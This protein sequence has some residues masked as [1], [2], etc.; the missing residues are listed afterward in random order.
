M[1]RRIPELSL[2]L[3]F[4]ASLPAFTSGARAQL[5]LM[6]RTAGHERLDFLLGKWSHEETQTILGE[7]TTVSSTTRYE[8]L[9]GGV[10]LRG[11]ATIWG[12]PG[13]DV[14]HGW[15]Q[16]TYDPAA[17][18]YVQLWSDNQSSILFVKRGSWTDETTLALE[19]AHEWG[20]QTV[21]SKNVYRVL[22]E[23]E[24][25]RE[26]LVSNDGGVTYV[27]RSLARFTRH[28]S[29]EPTQ[30]ALDAVGWLI[31][32]W[33]AQFR[34]RGEDQPA[35]TMSFEWRD[36]RRSYLRMTGTRP[37]SD[38]RLVPEYETFAVWHPVRMKFVFVGAYLSGKGR[39][40]EDG[41]IDLL[42]DGSIRLNMRV[43]YPA[44]ATLPFSDGA[45]AGPEGHTLE[46]RR[47]F[48]RDGAEGLRGVFRIK[49]GGNWENPHPELGMGDGYPWRRID[50]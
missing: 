23:N 21:H 8:W 28:R 15:V 47:T 9:P 26:Y 32:D 10:W 22:S 5:A 19:G 24:F 31:G 27:R 3:I 38:G 6:E 4:L 17:D 42:D 44:A 37:T 34:P 49:R 11:E 18:E 40:I 41:D 13:I 2:A 46:F 35:P 29:D 7:G 12:L 20:G 50:G 45:V 25:S 39:V 14:H 48:H 16:V 43:H 33:E 30:K 1:S 36:E